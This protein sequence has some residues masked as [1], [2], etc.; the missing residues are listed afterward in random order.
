MIKHAVVRTDNMTG[1]KQETAL[2][3]VKYFVGAVPTEIDNG[4]VVEVQ[5]LLDGERQ[6]KKAVAMT[7]TTPITKLGLVCAPELIYDERLDSLSDFNNE[8]DRPFRVYLLQPDLDGYSATIEAFSGIATPV[9]GN[10]VNRVA[11]TKPEIVAVKG[12]S[13]FGRIDEVQIIKNITY[14]YVQIISE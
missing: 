12:A 14:Y 2:A 11:G 7:P 1:A 3:H 10:F 5:G 6:I 13:T 8:A 4:N 9:K